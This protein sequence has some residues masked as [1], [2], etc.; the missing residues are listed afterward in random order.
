MAH[1]STWRFQMRSLPSA[2]HLTA[3]IALGHLLNRSCARAFSTWLKG[4]ALAQQ[5]QHEHNVPTGLDIWHQQKRTRIWTRSEWGASMARAATSA[6]HLLRPLKSLCCF[7]AFFSACLPCLMAR[8]V[9]LVDRSERQNPNNPEG[10]N[11]IKL[12]EAS[13]NNSP[14]H[15]SPIMP[16]R[17]LS[18]SFRPTSKT[19]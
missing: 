12:L 16:S 3:F 7:G 15:C 1:R 4:S 17:V 9:L 2:M 10:S 13:A 6:N 14:L 8:W 5:M 11:C 18:Q 19:G